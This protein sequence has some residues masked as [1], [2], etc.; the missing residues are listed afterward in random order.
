VTLER[1]VDF[2]QSSK[3][4]YGRYRPPDQGFLFMVIRFGSHQIIGAAHGF[5]D[6]FCLD[7]RVAHPS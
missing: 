1:D 7:I 3:F 5:A 4:T 6:I 2:E